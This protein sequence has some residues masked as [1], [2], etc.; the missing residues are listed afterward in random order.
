MLLGADLLTEGVCMVFISIHSAATQ[1]MQAACLGVD[2]AE[3]QQDNPGKQ[4]C[5][6]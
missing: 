3:V 1:V 5:A 2:D 6:G 4:V